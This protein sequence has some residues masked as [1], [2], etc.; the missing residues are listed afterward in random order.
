MIPNH[1]RQFFSDLDYCENENSE[2]EDYEDSLDGEEPS[3]EDF[4]RWK[5]EREEAAKM[6]SEEH[7]RR[8]MADDCD[9][10]F[11]ERYWPDSEEY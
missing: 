5:A 2:W 10:A 8:M 1:D 6:E 7:E 11:E 9:R 4:R 3:E